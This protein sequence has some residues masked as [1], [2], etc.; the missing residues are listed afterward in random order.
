MSVAKIPRWA[1]QK[2]GGSFTRLPVTT[3]LNGAQ[4]SVP[5]QIGR[6]HV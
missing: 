2:E 1:K 4:L 5:L 6:A 3:M